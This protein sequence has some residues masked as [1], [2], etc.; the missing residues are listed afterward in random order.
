[1]AKVSSTASPRLVGY[2]RVSTADQS[3]DLQLDALKKA[4]C[5]P[6]KIFSDV[7]S[8][9]STKREGLSKA[10]DALHEGDILVVWKLDR[11]GR[12]VKGLIDFVSDL[13]GRGIQ[14][15][16]ITDS[17]DT[18]TPA[19]RFF[20]HTMASLAEMERDLL[21]ERTRAGL[22]AARARGRVGGA[23]KRLTR[24]QVQMAKSA[25]DAGRSVREV[26]DDLNVSH[27]TLYRAL[28]NI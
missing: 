22:E 14:F 5:K 24:G 27:M 6:T 16:S 20:F 9:S 28:K 4:G 12:T 21:R 13:E 11:L 7:I 10:L 17:I 26:A 8:G 18:S 19:G 23:P 25:V 3:L 1:M 15:R 2:A